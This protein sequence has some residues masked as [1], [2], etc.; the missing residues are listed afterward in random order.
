MLHDKTLIELDAERR[1]KKAKDNAMRMV[2]MA[3]VEPQPIDWLWPERI[4]RGKVSMLAGDPG[5]GKSLITIALATAVSTGAKWPVDGGNAPIGSVV[6]LSAEDAVADTIR[7]RLDA[8]GADCTRIHAL[9]MIRDIDQDG[10]EFERSFSLARDIEN[11]STVVD[12][13]GNCVLI[14][15][16]PISAYLGGVDS[17]RNADVRAL[18]SPL[19]EMAERLNERIHP[20]N[21]TQKEKA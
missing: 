8:A 3:D 2:C 15:I 7:P 9:Q 19:A 16:D 11:L 17:H 12:E 21:A 1:A 18:L 4:A 10:N 6:M 5:L 14:T 13:L 20:G